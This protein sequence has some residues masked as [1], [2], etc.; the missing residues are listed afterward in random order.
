MSRQQHLWRPVDEFAEVDTEWQT[1]PR[2]L[3]RA[4]LDSIDYVIAHELCH[5]KHGHHGSAFYDLLGKIM[6]DWEK[7]KKQT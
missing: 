2:A 4:S 6:P 7:R 5:I 1:D 3:I